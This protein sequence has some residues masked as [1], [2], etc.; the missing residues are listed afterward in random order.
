M[1]T[2]V[3]LQRWS[4]GSIPTVV[5]ICLY[6]QK[7]KKK[8]KGSTAESAQQRGYVLFNA[9]RGENMPNYSR[10]NNEGTCRSGE[11]GE[12]GPL[13]DPGSEFLRTGRE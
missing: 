6:L 8:E 9:G 11:G 10:V 4:L 1:V 7:C 3:H 13:C 12:E 2:L 5:R